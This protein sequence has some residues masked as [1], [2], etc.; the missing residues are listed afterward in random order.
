MPF[1]LL[2]FLLTAVSPQTGESD[3]GFLVSADTVEGREG[4]EGRVVELFGSVSITRRG[5]TLTGARGTIYEEP[6]LAVLTGDVRG[7]DGPASIACDS[8]RYYRDQ[9]LAVLT[10]NASYEDTTVVATAPRIDVHRP[11]GVVVFSGGVVAR[12]VDGEAELTCLRL[13]YD[14]ERGEAR[15]YEEPVL[16]TYDE[17]G[18]VDAVL[19]ATVIEMAGDTETIR[20]FG[21]ARIETRDVRA[22]AAVAILMGDEERI[23]LEGDP[24]VRKESDVLTGGRIVVLTADGEID[25]VDVSDGARADYTIEPEDVS[26]RLETGYVAG[27]SLTMYFSDGEPVRT[28]VRGTAESEHAVAESGERNTLTSQTIDV[29]FSDG[30]ITRATFR[31]DAGGVYLFVPDEPEPT[32]SDTVAFDR[33]AYASTTIDYYVPRNRIVLTDGARVEYK[34]TELKAG[35]IEFD[36]DREIMVAT[37]GPDL[38]E[39]GERLVGSRLGYDLE[40]ESGGVV[41]GVTTFEEGLYA[42]D[43]IVR[44]SDG[45]LSVRDGVYTTCAEKRPHYRL[46]APRMRIYMDDKVVA[47]PVILYIGEIPV[48]ALP[49][50]V[51]P[52]RKDRHSGFLIPTLEFGLSEDKG[53]FVR[54]FGYYWAPNDYFDVT[55]WADYYDQTRWVG[56]VKTRY[57]V[58]YVLSGSVESS[59][60]DELAGGKRRWDLKFNHRQE[61]GRHW[62]AGASGDF[63]SDATYATDTNQTIEESVNR[64]L[65]S[66]VWVRGSFSGSSL[67]VT[68]DRREELDR[69]IVSELLPKVDVSFSSKPIL[70]ADR[71]DGR[72]KQLLSEISLGWRAQAVNDRERTGDDEEVH[73][74]VGV[75]TGLRTSV[76]AFRWINLTPR[77]NLRADIYDRDRTGEEFP[78]RLTY[79]AGISVGTTVYGT[80][81]PSLGPVRGIR[82]IIEPSASFSWR[83]EFPEYFLDSGQDRFYSFS[84]FGGTPSARKSVSLS[85]VNKL[86]MKLLSEGEE[87]KLDN[88]A[89]L[90]FSSGYDFRKD[91][92]RWSDLSSSF[93]LR[94]GNA[95]S[96]RWSGRHDPYE[97]WSIQNSSLTASVSLNGRGAETG[98]PWEDRIQDMASPSPVDEL[99]RQIAERT[100]ANRTTT[101]P[102]NASMTFRYSRGASSANQSYWVDGSLAFSPTSKWRFN[103]SVHYDLEQQEVASQEYTIYRDLHCW[104]AQ[105]TRRYYNEEWQYYFRINVKALEELQAETGE[106]Y[107]SR[108]IR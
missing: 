102:W 85:L 53:R 42:G 90:S 31:G 107:L 100:S 11:A 75:S 27:D 1:L 86:Q 106:R 65:H 49:F 37:E 19:E 103:Y 91:E 44:E 13:V 17:E 82:H 16:T 9:D 22:R 21:D 104:E 68:L 5:A 35:R 76:K 89:R 43:W 45:S 87:R 25:R 63:R 3:E 92:R 57:K 4:P 7:T 97:S 58:R 41:G 8:L 36:P 12:D 6:G 66:Q 64:S 80:F 71:G 62:T 30:K 54:N 105:F 20:A 28:F 56:H 99:R 69:D 26:D 84:G 18:A 78:T 72:L 60:T 81:L 79:D 46:V 40:D 98:G 52:I 83:P 2:A 88:L 74:G 101:R 29:R 73:Q 95:L 38:L 32:E 70:T 15:A 23:V 33:V 77:V 14:A 47:R 50:Y 108:G 24:S 67:G 61:L 10:G 94:P 51:F 48:L 55:A 39:E 59:F 93:E 96:F 34:S